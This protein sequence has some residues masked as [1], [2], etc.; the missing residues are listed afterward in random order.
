M[1]KTQEILS[2]IVVYN[3]YAKFLSEVNR[4]E[5]WTEIVDRYLN[6]MVTKF[7]KLKNEILEKGKLIHNKKLLMSMRA[8]QF[9][10]KAV[11]RNN[12]RVFNCSYLPM[13]SYQCFSE[14]MFLLLTGCGVGYSVQQHHIEKMPEIVVPTKSKKFLVADNI[15]GWADAIKQLMKSYFGITKYKPKFDLNDIRKKGELLIT[16]GG[17]APG[18]DPLR[19][20]LAKIEGLLESKNTGDRLSSLEIHD[21]QCYIADAVLAGGI[22]RAAM[23][24]LFSMEDKDMLTCKFGNWW[25][26]NPQRGRAN[27]SVVAVRSRLQEQDF[28]NVWKMVEESGS[29]EPGISLT[30][31]QDWGFNPCHEIALRPYTFCNLVE[32]NGGAIE[33]EKDFYKTCEVAAF[34]GTLQASFTDFHYL[35]PIWKRNTDKDALVGVG[36]TGIANG[37]LIKLREKNPE[38][39]KQGAAE[40]KAVNTII[41]TLIEINKAARTTTVKPA[42]TTSI[43]LGTSSGIHAWHAKKYIRNMQCAVG[44]DLHKYFVSKHPLLVET[45][46][47]QP[48]TAVIG[49]PQ[50]APKYGVLR[51]DETALDL[52]DRIKT[53]NLEW[54]REGHRSGSNFNNVS[55]TVSIKPDEWKDVGDWMWKNRNTFSGLS[56]LPYDGGTYKNA[57]FE[58]VSEEV[59]NKKLEYIKNNEINLNEITEL[60]D[61][62]VIGDTIACAGGSCEII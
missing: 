6:M 45:M 19:V 52:L 32:I 56:V 40:V 49:I 24:S 51:E 34:F 37:N 42:G 39:L 20:C 16:S 31:N 38:I 47:Y 50:I 48:N 60:V 5:N 29:G 57:P 7:P 62:T 14:T 36:I 8:A 17:K 13:D 22:R 2:D 30:D 9:S 27:N 53:Y 44:S 35:R 41:S 28:K 3:K 54:V 10:G 46:V 25:E 11:E 4:R 58:E 55:A 21:I 12:A 33:S 23:I 43:V 26:K 59:F 1:D 15:E 61:N 18:P